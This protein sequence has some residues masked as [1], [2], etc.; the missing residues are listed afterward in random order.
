MHDCGGGLRRLSR[1]RRAFQGLGDQVG[2][3]FPGGGR[4][5]PGLERWSWRR[6]LGLQPKGERL[7]GEAGGLTPLERL[8]ACGRTSG[9]GEWAARFQEPDHRL[10]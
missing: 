10:K 5:P 4:P 3:R 2:A 1:P 6:D 8:Q 7:R 9:Y